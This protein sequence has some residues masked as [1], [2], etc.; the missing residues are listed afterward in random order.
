[1]WGTQGTARVRFRKKPGREKGWFG[2]RLPGQGSAASAAAFR[3]SVPSALPRRATLLLCR[4]LTSTKVPTGARR[5]GGRRGW[6]PRCRRPPPLEVGNSDSFGLFL[7]LL[8][9]PCRLSVPLCSP[10]QGGASL[11]S[12][13]YARCHLEAAWLRGAMEMTGGWQ[14]RKCCPPPKGEEVQKCWG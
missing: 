2:P 4:Q 10:A 11:S 9:M 13:L 7:L 8:D 3:C 1:M 14:G 6:G 5:Y 12:R